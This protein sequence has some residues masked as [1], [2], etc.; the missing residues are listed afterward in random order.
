MQAQLPLADVAAAVNSPAVLANCLARS[1]DIV[2]GALTLRTYEGYACAARAYNRAL[3]ESR[4]EVVVFAHQDVYLPRG[5]REGLRAQVERLERLDPTWAVAGVTGLDA[6]G[7][8]HGQTWSSGLGRLVGE[9]PSAPVAVETLDEMLL[10]V[11]RG[12]GLAF[13]A[14]LPGFHLYAADAVQIAKAAGLTS[15]VVDLPA[16]HHS[17][18]VVRLDAGY[19]RAY[20]Y[21]QRKWRAVLPIPNL[22]CPIARSS[23]PLLVR[24]ARIRWRHRGKARPGDP[25]DDPSAIA[26]RLGF[27]R[28]PEA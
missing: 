2:G 5:F 15:Y 27:E 7:V 26:V 19:R 28:A 4:A 14:G 22:V 11:R 10:L 13:D 20:R 12:S 18:P 9:R 1:P 23:L 25:Q 8:L 17:R 16:I 21:M 3:A 24:D 6:A